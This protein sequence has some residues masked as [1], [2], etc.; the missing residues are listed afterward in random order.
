[1]K[2]T[3]PVSEKHVFQFGLI[4]STYALAEQGIILTLSG[5]LNV[6]ISTMMILASPYGATDLR[7]VAKSIAKL[8]YKGKQLDKFLGITGIVKKHSVLRNA[9]AH[10]MWTKGYREDSIRP[11]R[12][13]IRE[14]KANPKGFHEEEKDYS[15]NDFE[16]AAS[17]LADVYD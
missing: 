14:G 9:I 15:L 3:N 7:N 17:E 8:K 11:I 16:L 1:M 13:Q 10:S 4:T 2:N 6:N 12:M 5:I